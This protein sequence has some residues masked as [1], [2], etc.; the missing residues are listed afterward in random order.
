MQLKPREFARFRD[1]VYDACGIALSEGK[2]SLVSARIG[3]RMRQLGLEEFGTY[4]DLLKEDAAGDEMIHM[5]DAI[6]TNTTSFFREPEHFEFITEN[7]TRWRAEGQSRFRIWSAAS[8]SG[9]EP[10]TLAMTLAECGLGPG[11]DTRIL[12]TDIST[13]I[14]AAAHAGIYPLSKLDGIPR[15]YLNRWFEP[16]PEAETPSVAVRASLKSL[17][18]FQRLNLSQPPFPMKGPFD[19]ILVRN[20]MIYFDGP[21]RE[22]LIRECY[23]L[24]R[25]GGFLLV[26]HAESLNGLNTGFACLRPSIYGKAR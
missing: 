18:S 24:L 5:L 15:A 11:T 10:Y 17:I 1:I 12:A 26:G 21:T 16:A 2:E 7:V 6:S 22:A 23:R 13:R 14:L 9:E 4:L 25:P 19:L 8:S 3:K 20:V